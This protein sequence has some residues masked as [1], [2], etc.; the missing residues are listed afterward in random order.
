[1][2]E[3]KFVDGLYKSSSPYIRFAHANRELLR[4]PNS[5]FGMMGKIMCDAWRALSVEEKARYE[6]VAQDPM[7]EEAKR[8]VLTEFKD[9]V[10][11]LKH[12]PSPNNVS[13]VDEE[14]RAAQRRWNEHNNN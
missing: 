1:M 12:D 14:Y 10:D 7:T 13:F 3:V 9:M 4:P 11:R 5:T 8:R 6:P 2:Y